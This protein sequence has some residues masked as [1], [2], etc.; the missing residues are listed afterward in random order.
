L[1]G[2]FVVNP[3]KKIEKVLDHDDLLPAFSLIVTYFD[4]FGFQIL[5][6]E[7][8]GVISRKVLNE[9]NVHGKIV[10]LRAL[11]LIEK[12]T[13]TDMLALKR[14]RNRMIHPKKGV[15]V[16][17]TEKDIALGDRALGIID[18]LVKKV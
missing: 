9:L 3:R 18:E 12:K 16:H 13:Y 7:M 15:M 8:K 4:V 11:K 14:R 2:G 5:Q 6:R 10:L 17:P 1:K